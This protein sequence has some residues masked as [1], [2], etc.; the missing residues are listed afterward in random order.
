MPFCASYTPQGL[1][2]RIPSAG[3]IELRPGM[4]CPH[5]HTVPG[6]TGGTSGSRTKGS[7]AMY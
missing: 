2:T 1:Q 5:L 7:L 3:G 6:G 4:T